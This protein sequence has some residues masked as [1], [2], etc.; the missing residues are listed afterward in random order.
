MNRSY[1]YVLMSYSM[2]FFI[3]LG[4]ILVCA[5]FIAYLLN[6]NN[7]FIFVNDLVLYGSWVCLALVTKI[8]LQRVRKKIV[9]VYDYL[10]LCTVVII[11]FFVW[12]RHPINIIFIA[13]SVVL[14]ALFYILQRKVDRL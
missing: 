10:L 13:L 4:M 3:V 11:N 1:F 7:F 5:H 6:H 9:T 14:M 2:N 8:Y 12:L